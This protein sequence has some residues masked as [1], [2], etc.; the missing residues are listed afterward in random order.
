MENK[1]WN[2]K[3]WIIPSTQDYI[4]TNQVHELHLGKIINTFSS[5]LLFKSKV[6]FIFL[7]FIYFILFYLFVFSYYFVD[8]SKIKIKTI[9]TN[10]R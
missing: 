8:I 2:V 7:Y 6:M 10:N 3:S 4:Q 1:N 5:K 9:I